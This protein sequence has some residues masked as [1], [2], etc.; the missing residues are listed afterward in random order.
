MKT[1]IFITALLT[2]LITFTVEAQFE[3][4]RFGLELNGGA[5]LLTKELNGAE[6]QAGFGFEGIVH[7]QLTDYAGVYAGWGWNRFAADN[8]FAGSDSDFEETGYLFGLQFSHPIANTG[9]SYFFRAGGLYNH[10][11]IENS[12]GDIVEDTGHGSG[13][14]LAG[15]VILPIGSDWFF[16]PSIKFNALT[17]NAVDENTTIQLDYNYFALRIGFRKSF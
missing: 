9:L 3:S 12:A 15:G 1:N 4:G 7:Y 11:E 14:Q 16:T 13:L 17:R 2:I 8:A 5:S 10:I 6:S